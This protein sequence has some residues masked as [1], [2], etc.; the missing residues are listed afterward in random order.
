MSDTGSSEPLVSICT[1]KFLN[2]NKSG[3]ELLERHS[4]ILRWENENMDQ[5]LIQLLEF[6]NFLFL[7]FVR[8]PD[9]NR[10][11]ASFRIL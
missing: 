4:I 7:F 8:L 2:V 3:F 9:H 5:I 11:E 1:V 6:H 10:I